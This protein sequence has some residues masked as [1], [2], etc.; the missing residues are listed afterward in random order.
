MHLAQ[1]HSKTFNSP[2]WYRLII[3]HLTQN[4]HILKPL[5][6]ILINSSHI[7]VFLTFTHFHSRVLHIY[8]SLLM[9]SAHLRILPWYIWPQISTPKPSFLP[10]AS[11]LFETNLTS[12]KPVTK[13]KF[14][15]HT[16]LPQESQ[17]LAI[18]TTP[19]KSGPKSTTFK[20][21]LLL[22]GWSAGQ[23]HNFSV[24]SN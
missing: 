14:Q 5:T 13:N 23:L 1:K 20:W 24:Y 17:F 4:T 7:H 18:I 2:N 8:A 21:I 6:R 3:T 10:R 11:R 15:K 22:A 9:H 19:K 12:A 16:K